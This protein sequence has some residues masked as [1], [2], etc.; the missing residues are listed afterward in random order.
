[1]GN[2]TDDMHFVRSVEMENEAVRRITD[3]FTSQWEEISQKT[4]QE[5]TALVL[6]VFAGSCLTDDN[7]KDSPE[8]LQ[9]RHAN[10]FFYSTSSLLRSGSPMS[11][12]IT[13]KS[14]DETLKN[15][16]RIKQLAEKEDNSNDII[17]R[18]DFFINKLQPVLEQMIQNQQKANTWRDL[19]IIWFVIAAICLV[20]VLF[21][22]SAFPFAAVIVLGVV[23][24]AVFLIKYRK[25]LLD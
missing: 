1:M 7:A 24:A 3:L 12:E 22:G 25:N 20:I 2:I 21:G 16:K 5:I 6:D 14:F 18:L 11:I 4:A 19:I 17:K 15:L 9:L 23:V 13:G 10:Q 8:S